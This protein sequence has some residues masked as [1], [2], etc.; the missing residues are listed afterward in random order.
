MVDTIRTKEQAIEW[1]HS[2]K[3]LGIKPG[4]SRME[5]MLK[6]FNHPERYLKFVHVAGTNG[7]GSTVSFISNVLRKSEYKVGTF[8]SPYLIAFTNRI[9]FNGEDI[10]GDDLIELVNKVIPLT[11]E[12]EKTELGAPT[13]FEII[14]MIAI[15]YFATI[16]LPD[17]V[18]WETGLGGRLDSTN[19]VIPIVSVITNIGYDHMD[20]LGSDIKDIAAE[21]AGIIKSGVTVVSG[22]ENEEAR[23]VINQHAKEKNASIYLINEQFSVA[24]HRMNQ[25][26]SQFDFK[27]PYLTMP[28]IELKMIGPHQ[29]KNAS[30]ALMTLEILRQFYSFYIEE[31]SVYSGMK[32][33][34][35]PGRFEVILEKPL[36]IIDGAHNAE[37]AKSL[38]E[39]VSLFNYNRLIIV[40]GILRDKAVKNFY[41]ELLPLTDE[42]I[43]TEP[44]NP[45]AAK[46][47]EVMKVINEID[48]Y[49]EPKPIKNYI[50]AM[51]HALAIASNE[52]LI[53]C[54]GSLYLISDIRRFMKER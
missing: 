47:E 8:T 20:Y 4:L 38:K 24:V 36:V 6:R 30:V 49:K 9:Q 13:E 43:I 54:T 19:V 37:G 40:T 15:L 48:N 3:T 41:E 7:K 25:N 39:T 1:I 35:W 44:I 17:I 10:S 18:I 46:V 27:G 22:V 21:K 31:N 53:V 11:R 23:A 32:H 16:S 26:G 2:L 52:D 33:A 14:T 34:F 28:N 12:L 51:E 50:D 5:W 42:L 45:R 29:V